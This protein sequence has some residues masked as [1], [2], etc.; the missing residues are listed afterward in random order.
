MSQR[1]PRFPTSDDSEQSGTERART[2]GASPRLDAEE[3]ARMLPPRRRTIPVLETVLLASTAALLAAVAWPIAVSGLREDAHAI[4]V[5]PTP[6]VPGPSSGVARPE[7]TSAPTIQVALLLDTSSSMDGLID[8][9]RSQLWR[10]VNA[11]DTVTWHGERPRLEVALYEYGND[12][13][14]AEGGFIRQVSPFTVE[15]DRVSEK[16]F[17]LHTNGGSEHAGQV[18][19]R[20]LEELE[21][22]S[23]E[24]TLQVI[25][26]AGNEEFMQGPV[27]W[28]TAI[29]AAKA[30]GVVVNTLD[31]ATGGFQDAGWAEAAALAGGRFMQIDHNAV[32]EYIAAPQDA[33]IARLG[34]ALNRTYVGYGAE[35]SKGLDNQMAQ[36][37]NS[38]K[39]G[40]G[41]SIQRAITKS[42]AHYANPTWDLVDAVDGDVVELAEVDRG[43]LPEEA[44]A[45]DDE[46]LDAWLDGKRTERAEIQAQLGE[47]ASAR[48]TFLAEERTRRHGKDA[49]RLDTAIVASILEQAK[50]AGFT[51][52]AS[53]S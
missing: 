25:Y 9:A 51:I 43:A 38:M 21:W 31:C 28:R 39:A 48:E 6:D 4:S 30:R 40:I 2:E 53:A 18:I 12:G 14:D 26:I 3:L 19:A 47:L 10:V 24:G 15:L 50:S 11:I 36:D 37:D 17:A 34:T 33:E 41:S 45:L 7:P 49:N 35:G 44:K 5:A 29:E 46:A 32:E 42:S 52:D 27:D 22:R 13:L 20:S 1:D 23:G 8:Q 16:L